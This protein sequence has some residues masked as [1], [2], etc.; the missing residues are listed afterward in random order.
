MRD[1]FNS[2]NNTNDQEI[3]QA[4]LDG[5]AALQQSLNQLDDDSVIVFSIA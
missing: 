2:F 3:G 5:V 1:Y 4:M